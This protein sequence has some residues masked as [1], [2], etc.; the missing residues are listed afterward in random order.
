MADR[1]PDD[2]VLVKRSDLRMLMD[3]D[4]G[5]STSVSFFEPDVFARL[6]A[7]VNGE[8]TTKETFYQCS[9]GEQFPTFTQAEEHI[10]VLS[11]ALAGIDD[12]AWGYNRVDL[13][14]AWVEGPF[15]PIA[16]EVLNR[17]ALGGDTDGQ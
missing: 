14:E 15:V 6:L 1:S 4:D 3:E 8:A 2:L 9:D 11:D 10:R 16:R 12:Q 5:G 7:V 17:A 13:Y